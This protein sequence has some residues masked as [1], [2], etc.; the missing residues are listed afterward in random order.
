MR[1]TILRFLRDDSG[2]AVVGE[3]VFVATILVLAA[4]AGAATLHPNTADDPDVTAS[5]NAGPATHA[6]APAAVP[7]GR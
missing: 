4:V 2:T 5:I 7:D 6:D 1:R 3:W